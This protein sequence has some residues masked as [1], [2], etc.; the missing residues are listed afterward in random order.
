MKKL[1]AY[2]QSPLFLM[3]LLLRFALIVLLLPTPVG[4]WFVPFLSN[5]ISTFSLD[6]WQ[7]WLSQGGTAAAF[8]Y[9][10]AM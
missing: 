10:Y 2:C 3:G 6:P 4:Q 1:L 9:G 5:S 7:A 8:P